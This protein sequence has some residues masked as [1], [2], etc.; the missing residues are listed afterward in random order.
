MPIAIPLMET[1][2]LPIT[3]TM[4]VLVRVQ[5]EFMTRMMIEVVPAAATSGMCNA[6]MPRWLQMG[7]S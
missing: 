4:T 2:A 7:G 1:V 5:A 6:D 3:E